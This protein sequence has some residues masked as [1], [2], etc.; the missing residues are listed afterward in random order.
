MSAPKASRVDRRGF[1]QSLL[2]RRPA[3]PGPTAPTATTSSV[4]G[5]IGPSESFSLERFYAERA[6]ARDLT[7]SALPPPAPRRHG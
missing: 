3:A 1:L 4:P 6:R 7:P 2:G 5:V